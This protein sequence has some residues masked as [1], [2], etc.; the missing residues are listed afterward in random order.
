MNNNTVVKKA[1]D[2][3]ETHIN[4]DLPLDKIAK[5]LNYSKYYIQLYGLQIHTRTQADYSG[6][7]TCG[8]QTAHYRN[9]L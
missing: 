8:N 3:I 6:P 4:E 7:K 9:C 2:Y 5:A 1:A